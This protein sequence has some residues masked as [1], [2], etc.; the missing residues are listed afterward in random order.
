MQMCSSATEDFGS[1][2]NFYNGI[3]V[4]FIR[5]R[6]RFFPAFLFRRGLTVVLE[7]TEDKLAMDYIQTVK[8]AL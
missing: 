6:Y 5:G 4:L 8:K 7:A 1:H 3:E 2:A